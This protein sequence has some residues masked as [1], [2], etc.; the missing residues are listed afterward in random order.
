MSVEHTAHS[1]SLLR[2]RVLGSALRRDAGV[3]RAVGTFDRT[4]E[5]GRN[6]GARSWLLRSRLVLGGAVGG[7]W[8]AKPRAR[9]ALLHVHTRRAQRSFWGGARGGS[10]SARSVWIPPSGVVVCGGLIAITRRS[11]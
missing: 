7:V 5:S 6:G 8:V 2:P 4:A 10:T 9:G 1:R 3:S 11:V